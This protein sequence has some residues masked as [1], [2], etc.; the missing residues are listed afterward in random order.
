MYGAVH[1]TVRQSLLHLL[2]AKCS[3]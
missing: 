2:T 3:T 1:S